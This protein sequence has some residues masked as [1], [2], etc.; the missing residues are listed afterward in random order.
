M[1]LPAPHVLFLGVGTQPFK[2]ACIHDDVGRLLTDH[3]RGAKRC[4]PIPPINDWLKT[5]FNDGVHDI[6]G[7]VRTRHYS[8]CND[9]LHQVRG[10]QL[11]LIDRGDL[12]L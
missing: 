1:A 7:I 12:I 3:Q 9:G 8:P 2:R 5:G 4:P 11:I 6:R 10:I